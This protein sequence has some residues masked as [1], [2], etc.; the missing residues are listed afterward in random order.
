MRLERL[1]QP[2]HVLLKRGLRIGRRALAPE[3][4]DEPIARDRLAGVQQ[5]DRENAALPRATERKLP[6]AVTHLE[7]AENAEIE[8]A[9]Q[10]R[11]R[12]TMPLSVH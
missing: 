7:R 8:R 3:L 12:T 5:E 9:R 10:M 2:R 1:A 6:L 11:E 4:V